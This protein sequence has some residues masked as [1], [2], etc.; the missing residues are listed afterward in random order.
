MRPP[1]RITSLAL[2]SL[3][4]LLC[5]PA[6]A[7]AADPPGLSVAAADVTK[8]VDETAAP[9]EQVTTT[10]ETTTA[11]VAEAAKHV[12][13]TGHDTGPPRAR[14]RKARGGGRRGDAPAGDRGGRADVRAGREGRRADGCAG[15][16]G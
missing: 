4:T 7:R 10:V 12:G 8:R 14:P 3:L 16:K 1:R 5:A 6:L 9:V 11:P 15:R 2:A 13:A